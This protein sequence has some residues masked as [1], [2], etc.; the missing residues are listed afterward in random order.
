[1]QADANSTVEPVRT[2]SMAPISAMK[3][4]GSNWISTSSG[5]EAVDVEDARAGLQLELGAEL[6]G[7]G[8]DREIDLG[9]DVGLAAEDL[10][11]E[12]LERTEPHRRRRVGRVEAADG[13]QEVARSSPQ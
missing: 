12:P 7:V 4:N 3:W 13:E 1:M 9:A 5:E 10:D 2:A 6:D 11:A 8:G